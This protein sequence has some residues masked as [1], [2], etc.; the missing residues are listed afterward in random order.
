MR[1]IE[2]TLLHPC[3]VAVAVGTYLWAAPVSWTWD[4]FQHGLLQRCEASGEQQC[5]SKHPLSGVRTMT[6]RDTCHP[7][8]GTVQ[9][10]VTCGMRRLSAMRN[11]LFLEDKWNRD[12]CLRGKLLG[13]L[14]WWA[15]D[16]HIAAC[17]MRWTPPCVWRGTFHMLICCGGGAEHSLLLALTQPKSI[18]PNAF[19]HRYQIDYT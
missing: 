13:A 4:H 8:N 2:S 12:G 6:H 1:W 16:L 14:H 7:K 19:S 15:T 18:L 11:P 5:T 10:N 17:V 9:Q 3:R